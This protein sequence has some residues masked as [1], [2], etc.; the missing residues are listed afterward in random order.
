MWGSFLPSKY[1]SRSL[2]PRQVPQAFKW[3]WETSC[4][5]KHKVFFWLLLKDRLSTR[6]L[7]SRK[8]MQ[9]QSNN[10]VLCNNAVEET[11]EHLFLNCPFSVQCWNLVGVQM[12]NQTEIFQAIQ[13]IRRHA[14]SSFFMV[15]AI[16]MSWSIWVSRNDCIF[17]GIP[18][19][20]SRVKE[21][22][23]KELRILSLRVR[24]RF[25]AAFDLWI[26]NPL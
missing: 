11:M 17:N 3:I 7:L 10:C 5:P 25:T 9:L 15:I 22:F 12:Q 20:L 16:L 26:Q 23:D 21:C 13:L 24:T 1:Y 14:N 18:P 19:Q 8:G 6:N 4:Q 2:E